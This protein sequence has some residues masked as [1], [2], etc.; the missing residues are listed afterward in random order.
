MRLSEAMNECDHADVERI[1]AVDRS[2]K[3][4]SPSKGLTSFELA[5]EVGLEPTTR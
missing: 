3:K 1:D 2:D 4:R 5:P